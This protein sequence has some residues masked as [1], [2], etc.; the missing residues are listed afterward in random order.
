MSDWLGERLE[1]YHAEMAAKEASGRR[2]V[3]GPI[4]AVVHREWGQPAIRL[5]V[6]DCEIVVQSTPAGRRVYVSIDDGSAHVLVTRRDRNG[7]WT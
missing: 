7:N 1:R 3:V 5:S 6:G 2:L 4:L